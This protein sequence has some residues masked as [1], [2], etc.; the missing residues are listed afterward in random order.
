M[1]SNK[2]LATYSRLPVICV[3]VFGLALLLRL[4]YLH[5]IRDIGFFEQPLSDGLI[6]DQ[7]AQ[8]IAAGD[9]RGS[10]DFVHA[11][12]Y[13]YV[14]GGVYC[15]VGRDLWAARVFQAILGAGGCVL[16]LLAGR[17]F[18]ST[19]V[20]V[21]AAFLLAV[22]PP[23]LFFDGLIQ[24]TSLALFL[25]TLLLW[26]LA[27]CHS[28]PT[29]L[30]WAVTGVAVGLLVL[31][32][33]NALA[34]VPLI[35][36]WLWIDLRQ[37]PI[38]RRLPLVGVWAAGLVLTLLPWAIRNRTVT[39]QSVLT[40]PNLGQNFAMGNHPEGTGT[41]LPFKRGRSNAEHEQAEWTK[42][43][44]QATGREMSAVE[45]SD[46]YLDAAW[47]YIETSPGAW[48]RLMGKK[49]LMV[50]NA[51]EAY[52]TEDYYVYQ[53]WSPLLRAL[54]RVWHFG[55]LCPLAAA[56]IV[57]TWSRRRELWL[58]Y[59]WLVVT[60]LAVA[61]FVVFARYRMPLVP[62]L[63]MFA[64][65]GLVHG[66][67][68]LRR[69][70]FRPLAAAAVALTIGALVC[71]WPVHHPRRPSATSYT[72]HGAALAAQGRY[73]ED[74]I[75]INKALALDPYFVDAHLAA[76]NTLVQ[77]GRF[78]E[79]IKHYDEARTGDA[80][81]GGAYRGL[82]NALLGLGRFD[83]AEDQFR[84]A[85]ARDPTDHP[86]MNGLATALAR[87]GRFA[88]AVELFARVLEADPTFLDAYLNLGNTYASA[89]RLDEA[90]AAYQR[91]LDLD[92]GYVDALHNLAV[93]EVRRGRPEQAVSL[94]RRALTV[95]PNRSDLLVALEAALELAARGDEA[96]Y[97]QPPQ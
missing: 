89:G 43:A 22:Y 31:T 11:P 12:L 14:L 55:V 96:G 97:V 44:E 76:G 38:R 42:A 66:A 87:R 64:G 86:A 24:K 63:M 34:L 23:A 48:L 75:E 69:R 61:V 79:A 74:L 72:N 57:L 3:G 28:R 71:N 85:L 93:V 81:Y 36:V 13:A 83:Q 56:G 82:G 2:P 4:A 9:L 15:T 77:L 59:A 33:Q 26:L 65:A 1:T 21:A 32:R 47:R 35:L 78:D 8:E 60:A 94:L 10:A 40:T 92:E 52:D 50:C 62:V 73:E 7:R 6:Y 95:Q 46:Y 90:A 29:W 39:G 84:Q 5:T 25:S 80:E 67:V 27:C 49:C 30:R 41:Y 20:G 51:Y 91:A 88:E 18:F 37:R 68:A 45:V 17:R 19:R 58:L 70:R 53:E 16:L 54:D